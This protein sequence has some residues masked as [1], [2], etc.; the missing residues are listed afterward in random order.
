MKGTTAI[1]IVTHVI[2]LGL[3]IWA[4]GTRMGEH[5]TDTGGAPTPKAADRTPPRQVSPG[6]LLDALDDKD[7]IGEFMTR[8]RGDEPAPAPEPEP[9]PK[10]I[11]DYAAAMTA[12]VRDLDAG[13]GDFLA[14]RNMLGDWFALDRDAATRW[15]GSFDA[16]SGYS[17][18]VSVGIETGWADDPAGFL[19]AS[20]GWPGHKRTAAINAVI[21]H[22]R[23]HPE[24]L[25]ASFHAMDSA[26]RRSL[27]LNSCGNT[28]NTMILSLM[29]RLD[30][31]GRNAVEEKI[32]GTIARLSTSPDRPP[33]WLEAWTGTLAALEF[34]S[35]RERLQERLEATVAAQGERHAVAD[36][37]ALATLDPA[38]AIAR[39]R[40]R[41]RQ[42]DL[43][44]ETM[45]ETFNSWLSSL[46]DPTA[47]AE[48]MT[49][50]QHA[51]LGRAEAGA[52][53]SRY[54]AQLDQ[55]PA[56]LRRRA[57][58]E[59][60]WCSA[61]VDA[62]S[63]VTTGIEILGPRETA[64]LISKT[65]D[66]SRYDAHHVAAVLSAAADTP[67]WDM[68]DHST[69]PNPGRVLSAIRDLDGTNHQAAIDW[70]RGIPDPKAQQDAAEMLTG[71]MENDGR[72][73]EAARLRE[74]LP[75][76]K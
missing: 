4:A 25:E 54:L 13:T 40:D 26:S 45:E 75:T 61:K 15:L 46:A 19:Q 10:L 72:A 53:F 22:C 29:Q 35:L 44:D 47:N 65:P 56:E 51:A 31:P 36:I 23:D 5:K 57:T 55:A 20:A 37:K 73:T 2:A 8:A 74:E 21:R 28:P 33:D 14:T 24:H 17:G 70:V 38:A 12:A 63:V 27:L 30:A 67:V 3:G 1:L 60:F 48:F 52:A 16:R 34:D 41:V 62:T 50:L 42:M 71:I 6:E 9:A 69:A 32:L 64:R 43:E 7:A 66:L 39:A 59:S 18:L 76:L 11:D 49:T 68:L 58:F